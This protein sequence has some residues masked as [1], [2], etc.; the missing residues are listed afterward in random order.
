MD[1]IRWAAR[2]S[3]N[4]CRHASSLA[5]LYRCLATFWC[6]DARGWSCA[7]YRTDGDSWDKLRASVGVGVLSVKGRA[8]R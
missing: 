2:G 3:L 8:A 5:S 6:S 1:A 7:A 4:A